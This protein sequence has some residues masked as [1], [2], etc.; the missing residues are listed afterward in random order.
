MSSWTPLLAD[1]SA[2]FTL[3]DR[4]VTPSICF[5]DPTFF[6]LSAAYQVMLLLVVPERLYLSL[7]VLTDVQ[8]VYRKAY[9]S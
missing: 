9:K 3:R 8:I 4:P 1:P 5:G 2:V 6:C 7:L